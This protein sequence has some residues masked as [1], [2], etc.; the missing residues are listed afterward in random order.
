[1]KDWRMSNMKKIHALRLLSLAKFLRK[2]PREQ[3]DF[4][5]W[6]ESS[7]LK[8]PLSLG[9]C[10]TLGCALGWASAMPEFNALGLTNDGLSLRY[11]PP[12][13]K[14]GVHYRYDVASYNIFG[15]S[16]GEYFKLFCEGYKLPKVKNITRDSRPGPRTIANSI[17]QYVF[18]HYNGRSK[19][20]LVALG[21]FSASLVY[22]LP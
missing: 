4:G 13:N 19:E 2:V 11:I 17:A 21:Q 15:L 1:M 6:I 8:T 5:I 10:G 7:D 9:A 14:P 3:F 22:D 20:V 12:G 16:H 18:D